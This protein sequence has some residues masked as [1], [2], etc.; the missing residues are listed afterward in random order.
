MKIVSFGFVSIKH[1]SYDRE[2]IKPS[3]QVVTERPE[4]I[5]GEF[6]ILFIN[7]VSK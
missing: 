4:K 5:F 3:E 6:E 7:Y 1:F 2:E